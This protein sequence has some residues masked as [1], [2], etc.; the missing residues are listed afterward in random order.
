MSRVAPVFLTLLLV[1]APAAAAPFCVPAAAAAVLTHLGT[2]LDTAAI[3]REV[4]VHRDGVDLFDLRMWLASRGWQVA[5]L[6][7]QA[8]GLL[9]WLAA[10]QALVVVRSDGADRHAVALWREATGVVLETDAKAAAPMRRPTLAALRGVHVAL[11]VGHANAPWPATRQERATD[12]EFVATGWLRRAVE[13]GEPGAAQLALLVKAVQAAPCHAGAR[14]RLAV[15]MATIARQTGAGL[16][17][18]EV[19]ACSARGP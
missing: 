1:P 18:A 10:G 16:R 2:P 3:A 11:A 12:A 4:P 17:L 5:G 7:P 19:P 14:N 13:A 15:V 9:R 6:D 8:G